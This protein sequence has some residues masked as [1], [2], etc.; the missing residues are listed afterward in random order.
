[1]EGRS[2]QSYLHEI[3]D[4]FQAKWIIDS[5]ISFYNPEHSY[6][7]LDKRTPDAV[8]FYANRDTTIGMSAK[9]LD[10]SQAAN[11]L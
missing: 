9:P 4:G 6:T 2:W 3:I 8:F 5:W 11:W 10:L 7:A 1:M